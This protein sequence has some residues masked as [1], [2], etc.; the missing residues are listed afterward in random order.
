[1]PTHLFVNDMD[2]SLLEHYIFANRDA[3]FESGHPIRYVRKLFGNLEFSK[4]GSKMTALAELA[5]G[6]RVRISTDT[7]VI[8]KACKGPYVY[9]YLDPKPKS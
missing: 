6:K 4:D 7:D 3:I 5:N 1:M 2:S 8:H 9:W